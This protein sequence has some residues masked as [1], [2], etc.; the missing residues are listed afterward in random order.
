MTTR[1]QR[2]AFLIFLL[3]LLPAC[4]ELPGFPP[5]GRSVESVQAEESLFR[6]AEAAY[7]RQAY[8]Q[9]HQSY[10]QYLQRYP[11]GRHATESRLREAELLG[12]QGDWLGSLQR[13]QAILA[14]Q[15]EPDTAQKARYGIGR[16][17]FKLG[18]HQQA[19]QILDSLTAGD[20]PRSLWFS[21]QALLAEIALKQG[22]V[23]Q[24]F[25]RL[26]LAAQDLPS[27]DQE[28]FEDL[29]SRVVDAAGPAD[30]ENLAAM[31]RDTPLSAAL[32]LRLVRLAQEAG[33]PQEAQ[34]WLKV[35]Q[36]RYS[37]SPEAAAAARLLGGAGGGKITLGCLLPLSG[38]NSNVGFRVQRG[39]ELA[40]R[41]VPVELI[42]KD[43]QNN[44]GTAAQAV[45]ELAQ[46]PQVL[47]IMGP[48]TSG[49]AQAAAG[50]AQGAG[51]PLLALSQKAE[52][53]QTGNLIFQAF[54]TPRQQ[55]RALVRRTMGMGFRRF[56]VL[57]P[58]SSYGRTFLQVLHEELA[59][60]GLELTAQEAYAAGTQEFAPVLA[61]LKE[62]LQAQSQQ[63]EGVQALFIPDDA[64]VVAAIA[65]QL[66]QASLGG[67]RVLGTNL[68]H[69]PRVTPEQLAALEGVLFP[70]AFFAGDPNPAVQSFVAAYRQQYGEVPDYLAAQGYVVIRLMGQL[71]ASG[72][73]SRADLPQKL[74]S[75]KSFPDLPWFQG[76][77]PQREEEAAIY[78]LTVKDGQVRMMP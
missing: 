50:A 77:N 9:A 16:A 57:Y 34:K 28:W 46:N 38:E 32:L 58:E 64:A 68:V 18:Q 56:A 74:M 63:G 53:T 6:A 54:L 14:R 67:I 61:S 26:R 70:D 37:T 31:Y 45:Q 20:L 71:A 43:T 5:A 11:Q 51:L 65:G 42:F 69:N 62:A 44:P 33:Q 72:P 48:L 13:H 10:A 30:L 21:T 3:W 23:S 39:M 36:E 59:A 12:L 29:K 25:S 4:A 55:V 66:A 2:L 8:A 78:L 60:P 22:N 1:P 40:A 17:Y 27:G 35:L 75:L 73:L 24:A 49:V 76:F 47:A 15:P 52:L 7:R 19:A 41:Q